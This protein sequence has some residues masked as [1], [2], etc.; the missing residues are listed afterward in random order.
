MLAYHNL[1]ISM[2][3]QFPAN[4]QRRQRDQMVSLCV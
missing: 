2:D 3:W 1:K 4:D